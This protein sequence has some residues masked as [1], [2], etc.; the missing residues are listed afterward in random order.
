[1]GISVMKTHPK[2]ATNISLS[3]DVC[4]EA[5][6]L[7]INLSQTCEHFLREAIRAEKGRRWG[8][9]HADFV[10]AYN[11]TVEEDQLPL[12]QWRSF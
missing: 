8:A 11:Q 6:L 4:K 1:M 2:R 7:G 10:S 12:E 9:E 3:V 5:K